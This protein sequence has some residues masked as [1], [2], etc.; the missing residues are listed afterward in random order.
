MALGKDFFFIVRLIKAMI[1]FFIETF[2]DE[3]DKNISNHYGLIPPRSKTTDD[4]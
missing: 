2:G 1:Q 4:V 3:D